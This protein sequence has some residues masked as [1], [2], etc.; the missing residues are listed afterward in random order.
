MEETICL[1]KDCIAPNKGYSGIDL[2][3]NL[4]N[5]DCSTYNLTNQYSTYLCFTVKHRTNKLVH[6]KTDK[7]SKEQQETHDY[8]KSLHDSGLGYRKISKILNEKGITTSK[9]NTWKNT[10]VHSVLKKY[11]ERQEMLKIINQEY[12]DVWGKMEIRNFKLIEL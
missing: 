10:H 6:Y 12:E 5:T 3:Y 9:G 1:Y 11:R 4:T 8:I 2:T 7:Y